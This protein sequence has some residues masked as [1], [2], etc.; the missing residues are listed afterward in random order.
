MA[1]S[2]L[3]QE[4]AEAY[5]AEVART[6][7]LIKSCKAAGVSYMTVKRQREEAE[8]FE[9]AVQE[10]LEVYR[11]VIQ[12]EIHRRA[13][14][15]VDQPVFGPLGPGLGS[16]E[17]GSVRK[18]SDKLLELHAKRHIA[19]YRDKAQIDANI[20]GGV[21]VVTEAPETEEEWRKLH[22]GDAE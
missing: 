21:L 7:L 13:I 9:E 6:G 14:E 20:T 4:Q 15:G 17:I 5:L 12:E 18:Y 2:R 16:G 19:A 1:E 11:E 3:S 22:N 10:A 8:D